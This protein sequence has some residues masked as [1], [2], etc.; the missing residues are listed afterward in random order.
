MDRG[1]E[2]VPESRANFL[3]IQR[4][5]VDLKWTLTARP[6]VS[7][8]IVSLLCCLARRTFSAYVEHVSNDPP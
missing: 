5:F 2:T 6:G 3:Q 8:A 1:S 4:M 7:L